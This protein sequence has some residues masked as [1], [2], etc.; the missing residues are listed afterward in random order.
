MTDPNPKALVEEMLDA[1][2]ETE[3]AFSDSD[4]W[5]SAERECM[6]A[7][8]R[9]MLARMREWQRQESDRFGQWVNINVDAFAR[10]HNLME[11]GNDA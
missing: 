9:V 5:D 3:V 11:G 6:R 10:Q 8:A 2:G 1:Y 4:D 7:A